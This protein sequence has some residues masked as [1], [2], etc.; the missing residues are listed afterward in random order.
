MA[1][2]RKDFFSNPQDESDVMNAWHSFLGGGD[3]PVDT[4]RALVDASWQRSLEAR[5]DPRMRSG[6]RPLAEGELYLLRERQRELLEASAPVMAHARDFLT[7]TGTLMAL[8]DTRCTILN[9]EGDLP[10]IDSAETIHLMPGATWSEGAC[11]TN[12]IGTA[13]AVGKPVQIHSAE[14]F[15]E[16][17]K[18]WTCSATVMRHPLDGEVV[19]VLDVSGLSQTYNRQTLALVVTAASRIEARLAAAEMERRYRLLD[20]AMGRLSSGDGVVLFDR[21]GNVVRANE[22]AALAIR[23]ADG[24][25]ELAQGRRRVPGFAVGQ[26]GQ[27]AAGLLPSWVKPEWIEPLIVDG[28]PLGTLLVV[29]RTPASGRRAG[30]G[31]TAAGAAPCSGM[32]A[33]P[34]AAIVTMDAGMNAAIAKARQLARTRMPVLLQGETGVGKE[35]FARGI[36]GDSG[37]PFVALNCGGLSRELLASELFGYADGAFTGARKG[38]MLGKIEAAD[39]GT[40]F[41]DEIG[42]MPLDMQP[43]LLRVLEQGEIYRLGENTPRRVNF[44]L[45]AATH[46]DLRQDIAAGRFRMDLFYRIAV[47]NLRIPALRE[48]QGDVEVLAEHFLERFRRAQGR[49]PERITPDALRVLRS[50]PWPGNV[51]ELRNLIEGLV[52]LCEEPSVTCAHLPH[53]FQAVH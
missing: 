50:Y 24:E 3:R 26:Q 22:H 23:S 46:R 42:E 29:P 33:D 28:K 48:R 12:A 39:G 15:C 38:G 43:N 2:E 34:F 40:L 35:E 18:R 25:M 16:G 11:G 14:H 1:P 7:E 30:A 21:R 53:E 8:A 52:L 37:G 4:L 17:I 19:G 27:L 45:V 41:L 36:H 44:R 10:A 31:G 5:V 49:G 13:L 20:R 6:P 51:R 47:T 9:T 32:A